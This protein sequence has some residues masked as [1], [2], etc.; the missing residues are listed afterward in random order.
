MCGRT[1]G[2]PGLPIT[3][4]FKAAVW[5]SELRR[6]RERLAEGRGRRWRSSS[7]AGRWARWSSGATQALPL[8]DGFAGGSG[9]GVPDIPWITAGTASPSSPRPP[10][11]GHRDPGE[12]RQR[13]LRAA[14]ARDR[15]AVRAVHPGPGRQHH[16]A[17]QA[18]PRAVRAPGHPGPGGP[19]RRRGGGRG[20]GARARARRAGVEGRVG[21]AAR[22]V[23]AHRR[24]LGVRLPAAR[25]AGGRRRADAG[26]PARRTAATCCPSR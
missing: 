25:G 18:Q 23:P 10:R 3:F 4:G 20:H 13:G 17:A 7:S 15:R 24:A 19:G 2:Q 26:E 8:L 21:R 11:H 22:G 1:H 5:A 14:A 16:D 12:D 6:H 9:L